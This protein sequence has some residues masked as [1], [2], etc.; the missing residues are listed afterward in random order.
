[1]LSTED[2]RHFMVA[3]PLNT[4]TIYFENYAFTFKEFAFFS[5]QK[6]HTNILH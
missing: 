3:N 6:I 5:P 2:L 4:C 1:M